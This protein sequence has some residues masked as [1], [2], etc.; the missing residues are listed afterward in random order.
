MKIKAK[1]DSLLS[2]EVRFK[3][4]YRWDI[5]DFTSLF[6]PGKDS[7]EPQGVVHSVA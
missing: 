7:F 5:P 3:S 4:E 1:K 2:I 6:L